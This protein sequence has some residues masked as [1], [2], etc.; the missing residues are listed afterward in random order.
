MKIH[1][2]EPQQPRPTR[3]LNGAPE[4]VPPASVPESPEPGPPP[5][6]GIVDHIGAVQLG[7]LIS[8]VGMGAAYTW[9]RSTPIQGMGLAMAAFHGARGAAFAASALKSDGMKLQHRLGVAASEGLLAAGH[10]LGS[11]GQ[12]G[13]SLPLLLGGAGLNAFT[14]YRYRTHYQ[15]ESP[16]EG[17]LA[18]ARVACSLADTTAALAYGLQAVPPGLGLAAGV[19]HLGAVAGYY[20]GSLVRPE[21]KHHWHSKGFGHAL[22]AAGHLAGAAGAGPWVAPVLLG[23]TLITSL[24]DYRQNGKS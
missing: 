7:S 4:P 12:G 18:P 13:W 22:L 23:G 16:A 17:H 1:Y 21:M 15:V 10:V 6:S 14:D 20:G 24:Q 5:K 9:G 11:L 3:G 19:A 8:D 2:H